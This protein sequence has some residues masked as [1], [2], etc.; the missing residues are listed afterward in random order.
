MVAGGCGARQAIGLSVTQLHH[1]HHHRRTHTH[2]QTQ[3]HTSIQTSGTQEHTKIICKEP[4]Q[5]QRTDKVF[6][7]DATP[8][9]LARWCLVASPLSSRL[10]GPDKATSV[11]KSAKKQLTQR[12]DATQKTCVQIRKN[13]RHARIMSSTAHTTW[14]QGFKSKSSRG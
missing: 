3:E 7:Q 13:V 9:L 1:A 10:H 11:R 2:T 12:A 5:I 14:R 4:A 8:A 6:V